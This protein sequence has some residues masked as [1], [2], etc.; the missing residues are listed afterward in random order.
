VNLFCPSPLEVVIRRLC[1]LSIDPIEFHKW[2]DIAVYLIAIAKKAKLDELKLFP[3]ELCLLE[4]VVTSVAHP[5][6]AQKIGA[7]L[8]EVF[9]ASNLDLAE[10]LNFEYQNHFDGLLAPEMPFLEFP[11]PRVIKLEIC[12]EQPFS[13][14]WDWW[15]DP[16]ETAFMVSHEF[17]HFGRAEY[18]LH[19]EHELHRGVSYWPFIY[20]DWALELEEWSEEYKPL[21]KRAQQR[22]YHHW[23][24]KMIKKAKIQGTYK[25]PKMPG[26][27]I[28]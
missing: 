24:K 12:E 15:V 19:G 16:T 7:R 1:N 23:Q 18:L 4:V 13:L 5:F 10:Y 25:K 26:T 3:R 11:D 22:S 6:D 17:R 27:W 9:D 8:L 2:K 14:S 20:P 28:D 21:S